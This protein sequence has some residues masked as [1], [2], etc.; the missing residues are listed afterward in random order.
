MIL[1]NLFRVFLWVMYICFFRRVYYL[2]PEHIPQNEPLIFISNHSNGFMDPILIAAMQRRPVYFWARAT[3]FPN[4]L[5]GWLMYQLHGLPIYRV[6]EGTENMHKNEATFKTTRELLYGGWNSAFVAPEGNCVVQKKLLPFKKGCAR[7]AFKMMEEK[8]WSIDVKILPAG[9]NYTYHDKFRSE[10][11]TQLGKPLSV[12]DYRETYEKDKELAVSE[13]TQ[14]MRVALRAQMV[15][16][17]EGNE[18]LS[19]KLLFMVRNNFTRN[20]FPMYVADPKVC[21][22]EQAVANH[23]TA[24]DKNAKVALEE[25]IDA[26]Q[27]LLD[28]EGVKDYAVAGKNKRSFFWVLF[29]FPF[30]LLGTI[31][32]RI[33]HIIAR[34]LRNKF[35]PFVEFSTSFAFTAAFFIWILWGLLAIGI[36]AFFIGWWSL[37]VPFVMVFFQTYAY[38]YQ[39]YYKEWKAL[40]DY[41]KIKNKT[42]LEKKRA[43]IACLQLEK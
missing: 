9:V 26:Y 2:N 5:K 3:E 8:N 40:V 39:D 35:V 22:A 16:V 4:N 21:Q 28:E 15:Y 29:G 1:Y 38:H 31:S 34:N 17:E 37:L 6:E 32:G 18:V 36:S 14:D 24:L 43:E 11:Y 27:A 20:I 23:I 7:L 19:E 13:L 33:P 42:V 30:W 10:V 12:Q 41:K 25:Q